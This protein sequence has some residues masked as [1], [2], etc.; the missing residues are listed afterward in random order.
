V[1]RAAA[2]CL[3]GLPALFSQTS[4]VPY[5]PNSDGPGP[6][7]SNEIVAAAFRGRYSSIRKVD[8]RN[9]KPLKNGHYRE[10]GGRY[11]QELDK[12]DYLASPNGEAALVLYSWFSVGGSSSQGG[13]AR[14]FSIVGRSLRATQEIGWDTHFQAGQPFVT[15][16]GDTNTLLIRSAHYIPGDAHCCVSAMDIVTF[17]WNGK[18]FVESDLQTVL[19]EYGKKEGKILPR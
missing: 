8:F 7:F 1:I 2:F 12:I 16:D 10:D 6:T 18:A 5:A 9:L 4:L 13:I 11:A 19:S 15:F 14:V 3:L 17:R